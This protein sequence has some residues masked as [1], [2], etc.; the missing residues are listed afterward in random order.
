MKRRA[1]IRSTRR[2]PD[3]R[4]TH[5]AVAGLLQIFQGLGP[6]LALERVTG[7]ATDVLGRPFV[8]C[9]LGD[10]DDTAVEL[11]PPRARQTL[12][13]HVPRQ[14]VLED[15]CGGDRRA[16]LIQQLG[17]L[18]PLHRRGQR[19][20]AT[21]PRWRTRAPAGRRRQ[22]RRRSGALPCPRRPAARF[23]SPECPEPS[24]ARRPT[25]RTDSRDTTPRVPSRAPLS[26]RDCTLS[27]RKSGL[28]AV[29][30]T[31]YCFT[32]V[33]DA[34]EP[35][36]LSRSWLAESEA[37]GPRFELSVVTEIAAP[38]LIF[39]AAVREEKQHIL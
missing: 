6:E 30:S 31:R 24:P 7:E 26:A 37:R 34:S 27:S 21:G 9:L 29:R 2:L 17:S 12:V 1:P 22:W 25:V 13:G 39:L 4:R 35:S 18:Q 8:S 20:G 36:R 28:P 32:E 16:V 33:R 5:R 15:I 11:A 10:R 23:A 3:R 14:G 19:L 38:V